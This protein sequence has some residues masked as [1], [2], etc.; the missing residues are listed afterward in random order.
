MNKENLHELI[1]RYEDNIGLIYGDEHD[2][3]FKWR[4]MNHGN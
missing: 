4:A 3:L 1:N 2:E